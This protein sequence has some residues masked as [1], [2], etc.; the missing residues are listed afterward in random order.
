M[1]EGL[2]I[3]VRIGNLPDSSMRA[4]RV[5]AIRYIACASW[6]YLAKR[7]TPATPQDL[8]GHDCISF[9]TLSHAERWPLWRAAAAAGRG[10][11]ALDGEH[12]RRGD[13]RGQSW[14]RHRA[15]T[16]LSG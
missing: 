4:A 5:G 8:A 15:S 1:E 12:G 13:R 7:G 11:P 14:A 16:F 6:A 9:T 2:D 3:G 10:Q